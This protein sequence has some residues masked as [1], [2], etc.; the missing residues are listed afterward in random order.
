MMNVNEKETA[1][2]TEKESESTQTKKPVSIRRMKEKKKL[3]LFTKALLIYVGVLFFAGICLLGVCYQV[4]SQYEDSQPKHVIEDVCEDVLPYL[5]D[6]LAEKYKGTLS[7]YEEWDKVFSEVF[8][9]AFDG[10]YT[11]KKAVKEYTAENPVFSIGTDS[12]VANITLAKSSETSS[13]GFAVWEISRVDII[14]DLTGVSTISTV[15]EVPTGAQVTVNGKT[16]TA[17]PENTVQ[18][19][20]PSQYE[21]NAQ[22]PEYSVYRVEGLYSEPQVA[23]LLDG[24]TLPKKDHDAKIAFD[25]PDSMRHTLTVT[26]PYYSMVKVG[27]VALTESN[28]QDGK[29][30]FGSASR[31][32]NAHYIKY[33]VSGLVSK[34]TVEAFSEDGKKMDGVVESESYAYTLSY[35]EADAHTVK[36]LFPSADTTLSINGVDATGEVTADKKA[37][38]YLYTDGLS[39]YIKGHIALGYVELGGIYGEPEVKCTDKSGAALEVVV[40]ESDGVMLYTFSPKADYTLKDKYESYA[41]AYTDDYIGYCSGGYQIVD[42]TFSVAAAHLEWGSPA[43]KKLYSTKFSFGKN[44]PYTV[45]NKQITTYGYISLGDN[46]FSCL[47]DFE[48]DVT[49]SYEVEQK[50]Q[51]DKV[52]GMRLTF[53]RIGNNWK[54]VGLSM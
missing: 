34:P 12:D 4:L 35:T 21:G 8:A 2:V 29:V 7:E 5:K 51:H 13:F 22:L 24:N 17:Q 45:T 33:S 27:G 31:Y 39:K 42:Q 1:H 9:P 20:F 50:T 49:T 40:T 3:S 41:L 30:A 25:Y 28:I 19:P 48:M 53:A 54:I 46:A 43:Y 52:E 32:D 26:V 38:A 16:L 14:A 15:I 37:P 44:K 10:E 18:Y 11:Y 36:V 23:A 47:V 6:A